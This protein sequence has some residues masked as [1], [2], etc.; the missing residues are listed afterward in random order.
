MGKVNQSYG[1][2]LD[3]TVDKLHYGS[4]HMKGELGISDYTG[5]VADVG[6]LAL[7]RTALYCNYMAVSIVSH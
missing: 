2:Q 4:K 5:T 3:F 6:L 7:N 1:Q